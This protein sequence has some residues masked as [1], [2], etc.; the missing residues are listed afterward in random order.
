MTYDPLEASR[1]IVANFLKKRGGNRQTRKTDF[2]EEGGTMI[3]RVTTFKT[4]VTPW[5]I[6]RGDM[7]FTEEDLGSEVE[8]LAVPLV[9]YFQGGAGGRTV[10]GIAKDY[11]CPV[12]RAYCETPK[13]ERN[14]R[15]RPQDFY[16]V[17]AMDMRRPSEGFK[18]IAFKRS[19]WMGEHNQ[20]QQQ[21]TYG[22]YNLIAGYPLDPKERA[23]QLEEQGRD[24]GP[25]L[26][27]TL[28]AMPGYGYEILGAKGQDIIIDKV[29]GQIGSTKCLV[30]N[31][32][33]R[34]GPV[35][36]RPRTDDQGTALNAEIPD[37]L[38]DTVTDLMWLEECYPGWASDGHY[39]PHRDDPELM[40][41][42]EIAAEAYR[43]S[44]I[45][46]DP[47]TSP[48]DASR[49]RDEEPLPEAVIALEYREEVPPTDFTVDPGVKEYAEKVAATPVAKKS[50]P[51]ILKGVA[52]EAASGGVTYVGTA[53]GAPSKGSVHVVLKADEQMYRDVSEEVA[54]AI[55]AQKTNVFKFDVQD[56]K[57][58]EPVTEG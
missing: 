30:L 2:P 16:V 20:Q 32:G 11:D 55:Q 4:I 40:S 9:R 22:A 7:G 36:L 41:K 34:Q 13:K 17:N 14:T 50:K 15:E 45:G 38:M 49:Q 58:I 28:P 12:F 21:I 10:N 35:R 51:K 5:H 52:V 23:K 18:P 33:H 42:F 27:L 53:K 1:K 44:G 37:N 57:V 19:E 39:V 26:A 31:K 46:G 8:I 56:V 29:K 47:E 24:E 54:S 43:A 48:V 3:Y 25:T 6:A